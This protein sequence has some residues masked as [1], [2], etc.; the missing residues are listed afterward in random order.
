MRGLQ[1]NHGTCLGARRGRAVGAGR[2]PRVI[3][4]LAVA[5]YVY[6]QTLMDIEVCYKMLTRAVA[7]S[8]SITCNGFGI[9]VEVSVQESRWYPLKFRL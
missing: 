1:L 4:L 9:E 8:R 2:H 7:K 6:N 3:I 5:I